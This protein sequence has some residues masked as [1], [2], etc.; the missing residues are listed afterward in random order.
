MCN[1]AGHRTPWAVGLFFCFGLGAAL[2]ARVGA[3]TG[4]PPK[5]P[6]T[7]AECIAIAQ[8]NQPAIAVLEAEVGVAAET[9]KIASSYFFPEANVVT[10]LTQLNRGRSVDSPNPVAGPVGD[11]L[12][13][14]AAFFNVAQ[15]AGFANA[16]AAFLNPAASPFGPLFNAARAAA[17]AQLPPTFR[18]ELLGE[19]FITNDVLVTQPLYTGGKIRYRNQ[20]AKLGIDAAGCGVDKARQ[21]TTYEVS[22]AYY[23]ILLGRELVRVAAEAAGQFRAIERL[24]DSAIREHD[25]YVTP[26]DLHRVRTLRELAEGQKVRF[27]YGIELAYAGL[28]AAMGLE[29]LCPLVIA[30][31]RLPYQRTAFDLCALLDTAYRRRPELALA[32]ISLRVAELDQKLASAQ[33]HPDVGA[34]GRFSSINDDRSYLNPNHPVEWAAGLQASMP[35]FAGGRR[36]AEH[37]KADHQYTRALEVL[38]VVKQTVG[39]EV[40]KAYLENREMAQRLALADRAVR[41]AR[42]TIKAYED[43]YA[44]PGWIQDKDLPKHF[45]DRQTA[46]ILLSGALAEYYQNVFA[47]DLSVAKILLVTASDEP[48]ALKPG[49]GPAGP[50]GPSFREPGPAGPGRQTAP[51]AGDTLPLLQPAGRHQ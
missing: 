16:Q 26:A 34:F 4:L 45:E 37:R 48:A 11:V 18:T 40:E 14:G 35:L 8:Q 49:G 33:F 23:S 12:A 36:F 47:Y 51:Q 6:L 13:S 25:R 3:G 42:K 31:D 50:L 17:L 21:Q 1:K 20:Q 10:R 15:A 30:E 44:L 32:Q 41:D 39:L 19:R 38:R 24:A 29:P 28:R 46:W 27:E 22:R 7:L 2:P 43:L 9:Q 5:G